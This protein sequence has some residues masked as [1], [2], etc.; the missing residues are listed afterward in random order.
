MP[1]S[2]PIPCERCGA[3]EA[4]IHVTRVRAGTTAVE[5]Y[6]PACATAVGVEVVVVPVE[7]PPAPHAPR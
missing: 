2:P 6:C 7:R 1:E 3:A 4:V 5:H